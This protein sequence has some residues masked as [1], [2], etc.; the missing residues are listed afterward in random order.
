[1]IQTRGEAL[2][3]EVW[4]LCR[5]CPS[6]PA[7][8]TCRLYLQLLRDM[9]ESYRQRLEAEVAALEKKQPGRGA[10]AGA[11]EGGRRGKGRGGKA[12]KDEPT[13]DASALQLAAARGQAAQAI[14]EAEQLRHQAAAA[15]AQLEEAHQELAKLQEQAEQRQSQA[16]EHAAG[17]AAEVAGARQ[18]AALAQEQLA[19]EHTR[20]AGLEAELVAVRQQADEAQ[21]SLATERQRT[22][23]LDA[24]LM[25]ARQ[26]AQEAQRQAEGAQQQAAA[27]EAEL[28]MLRQ[29][30]DSS[31]LQ[32]SEQYEA[33]LQEA[34]TQ[35]EVGRQL[36]HRRPA[37]LG[38]RAGR[39]C[40]LPAPFPA[41][42]SQAAEQ[43]TDWLP[44]AVCPLVSRPPT[45]T[46]MQANRGMELEMAE[47]QGERLRKEN[48]ALQRRLQ[49]ALAALAACG[50]PVTG[51]GGLAARMAQAAPEGNGRGAGGTPHDVALARARQ[52]AA[53][54][55]LA[56]AAAAAA[57]GG[58]TQ[59]RSRSRFAEEAEAGG[60][61]TEEQ[62]A[63]KAPL[64]APP[65]VPEERQ[66]QDA[67]KPAPRPRG[68][69][70]K[71][72]FAVPQQP[73]DEAGAV[74]AHEKQRPEEQQV[75]PA[76]AAAPAESRRVRRMT[77]A[78]AA[79]APIV[80]IEPI[81]PEPAADEPAAAIEQAKARHGCRRTQAAPPAAE[82]AGGVP[83]VDD[84]SAAPQIEQQPKHG[85]AAPL[86]DVPEDEDVP[87]MASVTFEQGPAATAQAVVVP[88]A[89]V[90]KLSMQQ[91]RRG[92]CAKGW[93]AGAVTCGPRRV[94]MRC[95]ARHNCICQTHHFHFLDPRTRA[96]KENSGRQSAQGLPGAS[97]P[98]DMLEELAGG[99]RRKRLLPGAPMSTEMRAALGETEDS[100][101]LRQHVAKKQAAGGT[102]PEAGGK[103]SRR[104]TQFFRL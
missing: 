41:L 3:G 23:S 45:T 39:A 84:V 16:A 101:S 13:P 99:R 21:A 64:T 17:L 36:P 44:P 67:A 7:V 52:A 66:Q 18:A 35:I 11:A 71:V 33:Q 90:A 69:P 102:A 12:G 48:L 59:P 81:A 63:A 54:D 5:Y 100:L 28:S 73:Q 78:A 93:G 26:R 29:S 51:P 61:V 19:A 2:A 94:V 31:Q 88:A 50:S 58:T 91:R 43:P 97:K 15:A 72:A 60:N 27:L 98:S 65:T 82:P 79:A 74:A 6:P 80:G 86:C 95:Q 56:A 47:E 55:D 42:V 68:R 10:G 103:R 83:P 40:Q 49:G 34:V 14:A 70:R 20:V 96:N 24:E 37:L 9:E 53:A 62:A 22:G 1:M 77:R 75:L 8:C 32:A 30:A 38:V 25:A 87:L 57:A 104:Q 76:A 85:P 46:R 92:R 4:P 89:A